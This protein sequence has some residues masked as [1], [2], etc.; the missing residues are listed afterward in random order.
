M[1]N[2][3]KEAKM[4]CILK[5]SIVA[6][7]LLACVSY[8]VEAQGNITFVGSP[9]QASF[10]GIILFRNSLAPTRL[11]TIDGPL[12]GPGFWAQ[13]LYSTTSDSLQPIG[14]PREHTTGGIV[15]GPYLYVTVDD[16]LAPVHVQM[17]AW[18]GTLWGTNLEGVPDDQLGHTDI[19]P[20]Y[21]GIGSIPPVAPFFTQPAVVP[22][23]ESSV[24]AFGVLGVGAAFLIRLRKG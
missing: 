5:P 21:V 6:G 11:F 24:L 4:K 14:T 17:V 13:M 12:A 23:P 1:M 10:E 22:I 8:H 9:S 19:V 20:Y 7:A 2:E 16:P 15:L 3:R 18:D